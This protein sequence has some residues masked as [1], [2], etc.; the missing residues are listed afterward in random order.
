MD[1]NTAKNILLAIM[2]FSPCFILS[3]FISALIF[4]RG[5]FKKEKQMYL[6]IWKSSIYALAIQMI[7]IFIALLLAYILH[8]T[9]NG[10]NTTYGL[11]PL[12]GLILSTLIAVVAYFNLLMNQKPNEQG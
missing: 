4:T 9:G 5:L 12:V 6:Y 3:G 1:L 2:F 7:V 10:L 11:I 8:V